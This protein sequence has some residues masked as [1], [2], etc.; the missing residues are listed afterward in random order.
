VRNSSLVETHRAEDVRGLKL[1]SEAVEQ[2]T[3]G[4]GALCCREK[5]DP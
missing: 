1:S 4:R 5:V 3:V 2:E